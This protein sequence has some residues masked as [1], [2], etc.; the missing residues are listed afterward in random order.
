[1]KINFYTLVR[2]S[3]FIA[4]LSML[5]AMV[6]SL[7][8]ICMHCVYHLVKI[9]L[10]QI[11]YIQ[12]VLLTENE[13]SEELNQSGWVHLFVFFIIMLIVYFIAFENEDKIS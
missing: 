6:L 3:Q 13:N 8:H 1:M 10:S 2:L 12:F 5:F 11:F 4:F 7:S 9:S